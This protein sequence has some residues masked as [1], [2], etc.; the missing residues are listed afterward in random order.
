MF[1]RS[2]SVASRAAGPL[3]FVA[4]IVWLALP[5]L[6][7]WVTFVPSTEWKMFLWI[8]TFLLGIGSA[9]WLVAFLRARNP[10]FSKLSFLIRVGGFYIFF[11]LGLLFLSWCNVGYML[12]GIFTRYVSPRRH[13]VATLHKTFNEHVGRRDL[14]CEY[15]VEGSPFD[16]SLHG[17]YCAWQRE[18]DVLPAEGPMEI[19]YRESWFGRRIE[20]VAPYDPS[21][22]HE[23]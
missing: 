18:W 13:E 10:D 5:V 7:R 12:P 1:A 23:G 20:Y 8:P 6:F 11:P 4:W 3:W 14:A 22:H 19:R 17:Y 15:Q 9:V 16:E 21:L 2:P